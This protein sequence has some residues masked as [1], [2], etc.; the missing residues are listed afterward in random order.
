MRRPRLAKERK[1]MAISE[2]IGLL[3]I[4]VST[5]LLIVFIR[6]ASDAA[7]NTSDKNCAASVLNRYANIKASGSTVETPITGCQPKEV[8]INGNDLSTNSDIARAQVE[9]QIADQ[10]ASCWSTW[11]RGNY[12]LFLNEGQYCGQC[13]VISLDKAAQTKVSDMSDFGKFIDTT[14]APGTLVTYSEFL[15]GKQESDLYNF[16]QKINEAPVS[17]PTDKPLTVF[18]YTERV[19]ETTNIINLVSGGYVSP[20]EQT[21]IV[22]GT[23]GVAGSAAAGLTLTS[24]AGATIAGTIMTLGGPVIIGAAIAT[25]WWQSEKADKWFTYSAIYLT[26]LDPNNPNVAKCQQAATP[27][28]SP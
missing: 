21:V 12:Q 3:L 28:Q 11:G 24:I 27:S 19:R 10:M 1:G 23:V 16:N 25:I 17:I 8:N 14:K 7:S 6:G 15:I 5:T 26:P 22:G 4:L 2:L 13:A 9:K 20:T 18:F